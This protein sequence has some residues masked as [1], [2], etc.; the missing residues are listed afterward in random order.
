MPL[1][2]EEYYYEDYKK[3]VYE[4]PQTI[5]QEEPVKVK[6]PKKK[7]KNRLLLG[8]IIFALALT[9]VYR[10]TAINALN[11]EVIKLKSE[12]DEINTLNTQL[13]FA[14]E[15]NVNLS[16]I[17]KY[18]TDELGMQKLQNY[19]I[20]YIVLDKQDLLANENAVEEPSFFKKIINNIVEFFN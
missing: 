9:M 14:A 6:K 8:V 13:K 19:Q 5:K 7:S 18:A 16:E 20:E 10:F 15:S 17:E 12:L 11:L 2:Q 1:R 3:T 4:K